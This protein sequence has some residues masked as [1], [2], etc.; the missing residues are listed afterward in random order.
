MSPSPEHTE[1]AV[2]QLKTKGPVSETRDPMWADREQN[3]NPRPKQAWDDTRPEPI[4]VIRF[5]RPKVEFISRYPL[6]ELDVGEG[7]FVENTTLDRDL[8]FKKEVFRANKLYSA[9]M[10]DE[11]GAEMLEEIQVKGP[12]FQNGKPLLNSDG[13]PV[14]ATS[15]AWVP[16]G[17]YW[18][19][20]SVTPIAAGA[21]FSDGNAAPVDGVVVMR[22]L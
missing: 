16:Q 6:A 7:F 12:Q 3:K 11:N 13:T 22:E 21:E 19:Y 10:R 2:Q 4:K 20:F 1:Q 8:L 17:L 9:T 18:R 15:V 5:T 14:I